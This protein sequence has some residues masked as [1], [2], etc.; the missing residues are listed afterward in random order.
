[1]S[2]LLYSTDKHKEL[3]STSERTILVLVT[4]EQEVLIFLPDGINNVCLI[5]NG[6]YIQILLLLVNQI[7]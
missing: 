5:I 1:M 3:R 7:S 2:C 6:W 4:L